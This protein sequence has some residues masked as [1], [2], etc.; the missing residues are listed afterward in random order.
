MLELSTSKRE[1][2][3]DGGNRHEELG[4]RGFCVR[5][6]W[7][8]PMRQVRLLIRRVIT[9]ITRSSQPNQASRT[10]DYSYLLVS[11]ISLSS[12]SPFSL[13]LVHNSTI[14]REHKVKSSLSISPW[15]DHE[16]TS[17]KAYTEYS[18]LPWS[19]VFP[20]FPW[21]RVDPWMVL[22]LQA[23]LPTQF[24]QLRVN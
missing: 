9:P 6:N 5:V 22:Q 13:F 20:S 10:P 23:Y 3:G 14:I 17:S 8:S 16:L 15:H 18:I 1:I 12:S 24:S 19:F 21:L 4:L 2:W 11:S 7:L